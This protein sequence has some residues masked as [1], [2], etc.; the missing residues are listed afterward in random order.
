M[1]PSARTLQ[2]TWV[3][4]PSRG[5]DSLTRF[6]WPDSEG[7][8]TCPFVIV[9]RW[10]FRSKEKWRGSGF[11]EWN[12]ALFEFNS[13]RW[14]PQ[15]VHILGLK[16]AIYV[17]LWTHQRSWIQTQTWNET[18][19]GYEAIL[20]F[21]LWLRFLELMTLGLVSTDRH[22]ILPGCATVHQSK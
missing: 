3:D 14:Q 1:L 12:K 4:Y 9:A 20:I 10:L 5:N 7:S 15:H 17:E 18:L 6:K 2:A 8:S 21:G 22:E 13:Y 16:A 11:H 19:L